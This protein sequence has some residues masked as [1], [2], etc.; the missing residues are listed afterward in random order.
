[1]PN[2]ISAEDSD[3]SIG[4]FE[5]RGDEVMEREGMAADLGFWLSFGLI[6]NGVLEW[7]ISRVLK[8]LSVCPRV[9][10]SQWICVSLHL[11]AS[12]SG[13]LQFFHVWEKSV[14]DV[15]AQVCFRNLNRLGG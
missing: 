3:G 4:K 13:V 7:S 11:S 1:M 15:L 6:G 12:L 14:P 10:V 9:R 5:S 8:Y 2:E